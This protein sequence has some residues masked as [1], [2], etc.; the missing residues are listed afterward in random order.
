M[1]RALQLMERRPLVI[2]IDDKLHAGG[3]LLGEKDYEAFLEEGDPDFAWSL[4]EDEWQAI[5]SSPP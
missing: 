4:P 3:S 1:Q 5:A 2:D